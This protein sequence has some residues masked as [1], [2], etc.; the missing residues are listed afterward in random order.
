MGNS[1]S[2]SDMRDII[3]GLAVLSCFPYD[4]KYFNH[5]NGALPE[6]ASL[7]RDGECDYYKNF[8]FLLNLNY[9]EVH[10]FETNG[11]EY[12]IVTIKLD[13]NINYI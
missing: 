2:S 13:K 5:D 6:P 7:L 8:L 9:A 3:Y 11:E 4:V 1:Q 10:K 12:S